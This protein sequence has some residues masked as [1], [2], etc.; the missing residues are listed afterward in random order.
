MQNRGGGFEPE[1]HYPQWRRVHKPI[2]RQA[3]QLDSLQ[4][5]VDGLSDPAHGM[6]RWLGRLV[7]SNWMSHVKDTLNCAC[8]VAQ[9]LDQVGQLSSLRIGG[10]ANRMLEFSA[11]CLA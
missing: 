2:D 1:S 3:A 8:L 5:L 6:D 10:S 9:C 4:R 11:K 7:S